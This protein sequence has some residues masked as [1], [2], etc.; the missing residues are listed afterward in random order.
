M[1]VQLVAISACMVNLIW[2]TTTATQSLRLFSREKLVSR[3]EARL[4]DVRKFCRREKVE[5]I[6]WRAASF[7]VETELDLL[8]GDIPPSSG[9]FSWKKLGSCHTVC[10]TNI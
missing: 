6:A 9:L 3:L 1:I 4:T 8:D 7:V 10:H 2:L 5:L